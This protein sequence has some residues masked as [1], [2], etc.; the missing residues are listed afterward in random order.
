M[1]ATAENTIATLDYRK[2]W[3]TEL[4][5]FREHLHRLDRESLRMRF[6]RAV[7]A[8]FI[9]RYCDTVYALNS[10]VYG[11]FIGGT[12]RAVAELRLLTDTWPFEAELAFSVERDW[13]DDGIGTELMSRALRAARN[14]SISR[15]YMICLPENGRMRRVAM[16]Y[17]ALLTF[18]PGQVDADLHPS[19]PDYL[20]VL[21]E[22]LDDTSGFMTYMLDLRR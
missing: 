18:H 14:R 8:E 5:L 11:C 19:H 3:P 12:L 22:F 2:L 13:Q 21:Q 16:K 7:G 20:S 9:D 1:T 10:V 15:L 17:D 4:G 6:G